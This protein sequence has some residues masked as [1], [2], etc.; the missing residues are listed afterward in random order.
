MCSA[1]LA[2]N[3]MPPQPQ[4]QNDPHAYGYSYLQISADGKAIQNFVHDRKYLGWLTV[5][6]V[7]INRRPAEALPSKQ[8]LANPNET[9]EHWMLRTGWKYFEA[10]AQSSRIGPGRIEFGSGDDGGFEPLFAAMKRKEVIP[11]AELAFYAV[12]GGAYIGKYKI[13]GIRVLS[14][15]DVTASACPCTTLR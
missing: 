4:P 5:E 8:A 2:Q 12:D 11:S 3:R 9:P 13:S 1:S 7:M 14:I 10:V 6:V 15:D